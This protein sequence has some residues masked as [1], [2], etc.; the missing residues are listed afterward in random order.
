MRLKPIIMKASLETD[1]AALMGVAAFSILQ[2]ILRSRDR[3]SST[4]RA[5]LLAILLGNTS[6]TEATIQLLED[7]CLINAVPSNRILMQALEQNTSHGLR[8]ME[9]IL[10]KII[11]SRRQIHKQLSWSETKNMAQHFPQYFEISELDQYEANMW[12][13]D[14]DSD[15]DWG[16]D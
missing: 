8:I 5:S 7:Q 4:S 14:S 2:V 3:R 11:G 13:P 1:L 16:S 12:E 6:N 10:N 15:S 9:T